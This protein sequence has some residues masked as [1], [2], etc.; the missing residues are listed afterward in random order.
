MV[1]SIKINTLNASILLLV[2]F[3]AYI[4]IHPFIAA[5][6]GSSTR[7]FALIKIWKDIL[8]GLIAIATITYGL[9]RADIHKKLIEDRLIWFA[10]LYTLLTFT[11]FIISQSYENKSGFA[12]LIFNLRFIALFFIVRILIY[13]FVKSDE[14]TAY[15]RSF[16]S[17]WVIAIAT[18]VAL[19]GVVQT[20][21][22]PSNFMTNFGY[23]G[24][25]TIN[26]V[27]TVDDNA[28]VR[29]AFSTLNDANEFGAYLIIP[30]MLGIEKLMRTKKWYYAAGTTTMV[31]GLYLSHSRAAILGLVASCA[32]FVAPYINRKL[33]RQR[34]IFVSVGIISMITVILITAIIYPPVRLA[35]F[36]S[37]SKDGSLIQG[38]TFDHYSATKKGI[39]DAIN[40]PLGRGVGEAG[41]A[42]FYHT[43]DGKSR[44]AEN[45]YIQVA[46]EV[47]FAG[48][49]LF[50]AAVITGLR[51]I[52]STR[53]MLYSKSF[54]AG[55]IGVSIV[56]IFLHT[57]ASDVVSYIAWGLLGVFVPSTTPNKKGSE[58]QR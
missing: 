12:G 3:F 18:L 26:P 29:R 2:I 35:V 19:F 48:L 17:K 42:S 24:V 5:M 41:P 38:S 40:H 6:V 43:A 33:N 1:K 32:V 30:I 50:I 13:G 56:A 10:S 14:K 21:I 37:S 4:S 27:S 20:L 11:I 57:W 8:I 15:V 36:H 54:F 39:R 45:Y 25:T 23:N 16:L 9:V 55:F 47:G 34:A 51:Q 58:K 49:A 7:N 46:Q 52:L 31:L 53:D 28:N 44:I 22:L